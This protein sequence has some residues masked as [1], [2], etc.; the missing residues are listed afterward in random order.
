MRLYNLIIK[1][2]KYRVKEIMT[3]IVKTIKQKIK[4]MMNPNFPLIRKKII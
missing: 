1:D 3:W 4:Y 2:N